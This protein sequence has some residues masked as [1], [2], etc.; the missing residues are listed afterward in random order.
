MR[1]LLITLTLVLALSSCEKEELIVD[2]SPYTYHVPD[3]CYTVEGFRLDNDLCTGDVIFVLEI[4]TINILHVF[5]VVD[6]D[7]WIDY[8]IKD[9]ICW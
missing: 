4:T 5:V 7:T 9:Q 6:R 2:C 1:N 3:G 8:H